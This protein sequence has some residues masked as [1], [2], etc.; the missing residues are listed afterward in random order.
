MSDDDHEETL[1][2]LIAAEIARARRSAK[3]SQRE[4]AERA[5]IDQAMISRLEAGTR[6]PRLET[7]LALAEATGHALELRLKRR[8]RGAAGGKLRGR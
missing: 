1:E 8:R 2:A 4:L 6:L 3:L 5:G 7:L